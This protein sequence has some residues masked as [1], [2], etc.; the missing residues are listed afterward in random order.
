MSDFRW[1][2]P[3]SWLS[4]SWRSFLYSS[5][6]CSYQLFLISS[7]FVRSI[8]LLSF[9]VPSLHKHSLS[10]SNF[11]EEISTLSLYCFPLLLCIVHSARLSHL[12]L[13]FFGTLHSD[14]Y[15]FHF[16]LCFSLLLEKCKSKLQWGITSYQSEWPSSKYLQTNKC[17]RGCGEK[18]TLLYYWW[19]YKLIQPLWRT[20]LFSHSVVSDSLWPHGLQNTRFPCPSPFPG[21]C[22][23]LHLLSR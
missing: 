12:S 18:K 14:G 1:V 8:L 23:N 4:G 7:A 5:S 10:I 2:I 17:W 16:L 9:I 20:V 21:A 11:L 3:P 19:D 13:L 22:S 15:I 6:V